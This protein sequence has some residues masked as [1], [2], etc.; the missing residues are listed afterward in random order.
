MKNNYCLPIVKHKKA[1]IIEV[2]KR[3]SDY[4]YYEI[5]L[6]YVDNIDHEFISELI[7]HYPGKLI[8]TFRRK[9]LETP[10]MN[11]E[12]R[13]ALISLLEKT[14]SYIDHATAQ[15]QPRTDLRLR[16]SSGTDNPH[17]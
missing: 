8:F 6:D 9:N 1:E 14:D 4:Q 12:Q 11:V 16:R 7:E 10:V 2:I 13:R 17:R 3:A 5:W 15:V